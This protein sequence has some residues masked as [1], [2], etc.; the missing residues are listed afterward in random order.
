MNAREL[1]LRVDDAERRLALAEEERREAE[2][3]GNTLWL[4]V[5]ELQKRIQVLEDRL[6]AQG[7]A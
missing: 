6:A 4:R 7:A 3:S 5:E 1:L 2:A